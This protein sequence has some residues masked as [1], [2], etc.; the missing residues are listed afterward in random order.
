MP[1]TVSELRWLNQILVLL[2]LKPDENAV[3]L[4]FCGFRGGDLKIVTEK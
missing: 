3:M 1:L 2:M 4:Y